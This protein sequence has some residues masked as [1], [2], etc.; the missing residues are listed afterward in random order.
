MDLNKKCKHCFLALTSENAA[1]KNAKYFRNECRKCRSA[2][3]IKKNRGCPKRKVYAN[4]YARKTGRVR[5]YPC[6]LCGMSCYKKYAKAF[7]SD[8]CRFLSYVEKTNSCW[9]WKGA[10][11]RKGYGKLCFRGNKT[12]VASRV[13]YE[14]FKGAIEEEMLVCHT[15]DTP[16]C[17]NPDH[18][19]LGSHKENMIDMVQKGRQ[20]SILTPHQVFKIRKLFKEGVK[21]SQL[22]ELFNITASQVS[23]IVARKIWKH[24]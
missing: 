22:M 21:N 11:H 14:L 3:V 19:W 2:Q 5:M 12:A 20:Y 18:L 24:V 16:A 15:C 10:M 17:V 1:K 4:A 8:V 23:N 13:S 7:C 6:E 9:V